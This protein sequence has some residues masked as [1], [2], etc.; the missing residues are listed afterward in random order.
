MSTS[1]RPG[2]LP[3][4]SPIEHSDAWWAVSDPARAHWKAA[5]AELP[6]NEATATLRDELI[7]LLR[8]E[9]GRSPGFVEDMA[10]LHLEV[11][12]PNWLPNMIAFYTAR[13]TFPYKP[14]GSTTN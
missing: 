3:F 4:N 13:A 10:D 6:L 5:T 9:L 2:S 12:D 14:A 11:E 1:R 7:R 8:D